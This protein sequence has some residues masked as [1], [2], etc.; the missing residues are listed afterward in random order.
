MKLNLTTKQRKARG[1]LGFSLSE[2]VTSLAVVG[3]TVGGILT[4]HVT[5]GKICDYS[6]C[7]AAAQTVA[8]EKM[9]QT[10]AAKWDT[11]AY[12]VVDEL[13]SSNFTAV[14]ADLDVL[15]AK[16]VA[17]SA[18]VTT[19]ISDVSIDP[20]LR[21]VTVECVWSLPSRGPFTNSVTTFRNA[22]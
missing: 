9:E 10:R 21:M 12:P 8:S 15:G 5:S 13:V 11:M 19:K 3:V 2:V 7:S 17:V 4:G 1:I 14:T 22:D 16:G 6:T 20:P 18:T